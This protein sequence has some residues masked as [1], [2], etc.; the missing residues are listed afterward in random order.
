MFQRYKVLAKMRWIKIGNMKGLIS[1]IP[2]VASIKQRI[3]ESG[4]TKENTIDKQ[5]A[6]ICS[7][8]KKER[9]KP[10]ILNFSR[11]KRIAAGSGS[12][13]QEINRLIKQY[14]QISS[15]MKSISSNKGGF[16]DKIKSL[17]K[18]NKIS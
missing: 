12:S 7:M 1:M 3:E 16:I 10:S 4:L 15:M 8:T 11:K 5:I 17:M 18:S 14:E 9:K 2:G 6:I 13:P